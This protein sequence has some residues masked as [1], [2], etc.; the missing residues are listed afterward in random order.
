M[1]CLPKS[2]CNWSLLHQ[3]NKA[4][5]ESINFFLKNSIRW[6]LLLSV[7]KNHYEGFNKTIEQTIGEISNEE[8]SR[9]NNINLVND[10]TDK[11]FFIKETS[12][13]DNRKK[14]LKPSSTLISDYEIYIKKIDTFLR[15]K[16]NRVKP[17][18]V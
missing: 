3:L 14:Y 5:S 18:T 6:S 4:E 15:D 2:S 8:S 1:P 13:N 10:A 7:L 12:L 16:K 9:A 11:L 17:T